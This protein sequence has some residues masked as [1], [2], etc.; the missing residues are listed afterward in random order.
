[1]GDTAVINILLAGALFSLLVTALYPVQ[2]LLAVGAGIIAFLLAS[3]IHYRL[4][5]K[6]FAEVR[7]D[8]QPR[9]PRPE[10]LNRQG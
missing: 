10:K 1:V 8:F 5:T 4:G 2:P 9:F 7:K 6:W 3:V